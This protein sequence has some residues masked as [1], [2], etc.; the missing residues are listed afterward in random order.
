MSGQV[1]QS[2]SEYSA[3]NGNEKI[4]KGNNNF[5]WVYDEVRHCI[6]NKIYKFKIPKE[7]SIVDYLLINFNDYGEPTVYNL[8]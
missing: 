8:K 4:Y 6:A 1:A 2:A 7:T 3:E 5:L